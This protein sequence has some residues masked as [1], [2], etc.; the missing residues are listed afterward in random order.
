MC[1]K[2]LRSGTNYYHY[3]G[4]GSTRA[5]SNNSGVIT[6]T[7]IY[8]AV[9]ELLNQTGD[10]E[11]NYLYTG[12][13]YD[14]NLCYY[15]L[16]ARYMNSGIG[17]FI[18]MDIWEG[19]RFDTVT[20]HKYMYCK[21]NPVNY[22]DPSG[23]FILM[24][25]M[26]SVNIRSIL[27]NIRVGYNYK[28]IN[29]IKDMTIYSVEASYFLSALTYAMIFPEKMGKNSINIKVWNP[30]GRVIQSLSIQIRYKEGNPV[31]IRGELKLPH[32]TGLRFDVDLESPNLG[33]AHL[34]GSIKLYNYEG[35]LLNAYIIL[36]SGDVWNGYL[37]GF[38]EGII[39][40]GLLGGF[41]LGVNLK[42][43]SGRLSYTVRSPRY[44]LRDLLKDAGVI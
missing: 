39:D 44:S 31:Q 35:P 43:G 24:D 8:D 29:T 32:D 2:D 17:R 5:L 13:Q 7:Y 16:R 21:N 36:E 18:S 20:L 40:E 22:I 10:T 11:N 33:M 9:G 42:I 6:D 1:Y 25:L 26:Q 38:S 15:Y 23:M 34:S 14:P 4:L 3:D 30:N 28:K 27:N 12:E 41:K 37:N 19:N